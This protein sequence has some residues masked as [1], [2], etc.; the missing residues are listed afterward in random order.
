MK[1]NSKIITRFFRA[2]PH[3]LIG[4]IFA[5]FISG[6]WI[7][8]THSSLLIKVIVN[9]FVFLGIIG[10]I[11]NLKLNSVSKYIVNSS[12][13][14]PVLQWIISSIVVVC[15]LYLFGVLVAFPTIILSIAVNGAA[16][17]LD[18][19]LAWKLIAVLLLSMLVILIAL[20]MGATLGVYVACVIA[21][22]DFLF[23]LLIYFN[24]LNIG[25]PTD[26]SNPNDINAMF[27]WNIIFLLLGIFT[28]V[29]LAASLIL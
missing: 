23:N 29:N 19:G 20:I 5:W 7:H 24:L 9:R 3:F 1:I 11:I 22:S 27:L 26:E 12:V 8:G 14:N 6:F 10:P 21:I 18:F 17:L 2:I 28:G 15:C 16:T 13:H 4:V 25:T